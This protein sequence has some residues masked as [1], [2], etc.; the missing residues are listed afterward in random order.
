M[1]LD[2]GHGS[3][4]HALVVADAAHLRTHHIVGVTDWVRFE[5][6]TLSEALAPDDRLNSVIVTLR[7]LPR[8]ASG[9]VDRERVAGLLAGGA[10]VDGVTEAT[11]QAAP[12]DDVG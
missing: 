10:Q 5:F 3:P 12:D 9:D 6:E 4:W 8:T 2:N 11:G 1:R 7:P